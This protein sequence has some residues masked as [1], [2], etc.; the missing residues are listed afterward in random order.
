MVRSVLRT[1]VTE[2]IR[3]LANSVLQKRTEVT[4]D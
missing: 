3:S 1:N 2:S 4:E